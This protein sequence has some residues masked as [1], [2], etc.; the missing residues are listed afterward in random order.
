MPG[1]LT[2]SINK[3]FISHIDFLAILDYKTP[4]SAGS[5]LTQQAKNVNRNALSM[6]KAL[7]IGCKWK[8]AV[9]L[10]NQVEGQLKSLK[11]QH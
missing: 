2:L 1:P 9:L 4:I 5:R 6:F 10:L 11:I 8:C 3:A 7:N